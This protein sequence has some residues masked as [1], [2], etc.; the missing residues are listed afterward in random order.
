MN[1]RILISPDRRWS[2][3]PILCGKIQ[4]SNFKKLGVNCSYK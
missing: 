2:F 1:S 3:Q 4:I